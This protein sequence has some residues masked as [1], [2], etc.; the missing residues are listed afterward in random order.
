M[1]NL[2]RMA[3]SLELEK[4]P[5]ETF[6]LHDVINIVLQDYSQELSEQ[7][8]KSFHNQ[9]PLSSG[10]LEVEVKKMTAFLLTFHRLLNRIEQEKTGREFTQQGKVVKM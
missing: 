6:T 8:S 3:K 4:E 10:L 2:S 1:A 9:Y 5:K 7:F